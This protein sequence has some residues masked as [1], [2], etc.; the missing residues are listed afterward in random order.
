MSARTQATPGGPGGGPHVAATSPGVA[1]RRAKAPGPGVAMRRAK[2]P[3]RGGVPHSHAGSRCQ[4]QIR[5]RTGLAPEAQARL[6]G[7]RRS[8]DAD[9]GGSGGSAPLRPA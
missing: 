1:M 4:R 8:R 5:V 3:G 6:G 7:Q 9:I 2:A